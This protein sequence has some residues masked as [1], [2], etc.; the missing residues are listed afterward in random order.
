MKNL[1]LLAA[2]TF[3]VS[4]GTESVDLRTQAPVESQDSSLSS[5]DSKVV[6]VESRSKSSSVPENLAS[7]CESQASN[8]LTVSDSRYEGQTRRVCS[9]SDIFNT[10]QKYYYFHTITCVYT[11]EN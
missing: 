10:C 9:N 1:I 3:T 7:V 4:C 8:G 5:D 11:N 6:Y 2:V